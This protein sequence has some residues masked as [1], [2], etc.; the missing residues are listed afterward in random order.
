MA[1]TGKWIEYMVWIGPVVLRKPD[2]AISDQKS[3]KREW[4]GANKVPH[5]QLA[6][7]HIERTSPP[8]PPFCALCYRSCCHNSVYSLSFVVLGYTSNY[9][10]FCF[11][12]VVTNFLKTSYQN[13][14]H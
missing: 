2:G 5:H 6:I 13:K 14:E 10:P 4:I 12:L 9:N 1:C 3:A 7:F 8:V 11:Y